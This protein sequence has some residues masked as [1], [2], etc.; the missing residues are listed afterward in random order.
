MLI[1]IKDIGVAIKKNKNISINIDPSIVLTEEFVNFEVI[2]TFNS[3]KRVEVYGGEFGWTDCDLEYEKI[4]RDKTLYKANKYEL[5]LCGYFEDRG[6]GSFRGWSTYYGFEEENLNDFYHSRMI[7]KYGKEYAKDLYLYAKNKLQSI[8]KDRAKNNR[9]YRR[10][11]SAYN[12][13][14]TSLKKYQILKNNDKQF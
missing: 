9:E 1:T 13:A 7:E 11:L 6:D 3:P 5:W 10:W 4:Y 12:L 8:S 14:S 2:Q